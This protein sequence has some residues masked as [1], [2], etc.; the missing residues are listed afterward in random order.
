MQ[1]RIGILLLLSCFTSFFFTFN[2]ESYFKP[3]LINDV[4]VNAF[5][6]DSV[7]HKIEYNIATNQGLYS[8]N[9]IPEKESPY[10]HKCILLVEKHSITAQQPPIPKKYKELGWGNEKT[11]YAYM[12]IEDTGCIYSFPIMCFNNKRFSIPWYLVHTTNP[13]IQNGKHID[14]VQSGARGGNKPINL[15]IEW[16]ITQIILQNI[17]NDNAWIQEHQSKI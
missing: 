5:S 12:I 16:P 14:L 7:Y 11:Y 4:L 6:N 15:S 8:Q 17:K 2:V 3:Y 1:K 10:T 13:V 9:F